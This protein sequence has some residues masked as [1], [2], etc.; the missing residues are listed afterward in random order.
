MRP[1]PFM[2]LQGP[3]PGGVLLKDGR[4]AHGMDLNDPRISALHDVCNQGEGLAEGGGGGGG[5]ERCV[6]PR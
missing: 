6:Q 3:L 1:S 4:L 5:L 2:H